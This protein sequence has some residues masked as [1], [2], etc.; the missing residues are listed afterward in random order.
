[1]TTIADTTPDTA[2][3]P[4]P[5]PLPAIGPAS[6]RPPLDA[7]V[8]ASQDQVEK[9]AAQILKGYEDIAAFH[10]DTVDALVLSST[11]AA[12]GIEDLSRQAAAYA[13]TAFDDSIAL[14]NALLSVK[15]PKEAVSL[16]TA[17]VRASFETAAA[18]SARFQEQAGKLVAATLAPINARVK[19][20]AEQVTRTLAA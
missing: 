19:A 10:R 8:Q 7:I 4:A 11:I 15:T 9:A 12:K 14:G 3:I 5:A 20:A 17:F 18:E 6:A 2:P 1:M 13:R 16:H